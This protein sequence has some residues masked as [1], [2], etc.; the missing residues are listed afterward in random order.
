MVECVWYIEPT[1][2]P[3]REKSTL[4]KLLNILGLLEKHLLQYYEAKPISFILVNLYPISQ[5]LCILFGVSS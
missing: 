3:F 4:I 1:A 2:M 5:V